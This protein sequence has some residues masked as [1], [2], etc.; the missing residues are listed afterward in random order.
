MDKLSVRIDGPA[1]MELPDGYCE[2]AFDN[3]EVFIYWLKGNYTIGA[4]ASGVR[5]HK[6]KS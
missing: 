3:L 4:T 6:K 1:L 5:L 2:V